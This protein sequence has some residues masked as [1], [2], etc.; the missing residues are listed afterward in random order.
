LF[1]V[2]VESRDV[3]KRVISSLSLGFGDWH[4]ICY[5]TVYNTIQI[6]AGV[7]QNTG[8]SVVLPCIEAVENPMRRRDV[9][10]LKSKK[11]A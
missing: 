5:V 1:V 10:A 11:L 4:A 6:S 9:K 2:L 3:A 7:D 8:V